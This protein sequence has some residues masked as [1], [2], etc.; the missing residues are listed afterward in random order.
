[1]HYA[2]PLTDGQTANLKL[3]LDEQEFRCPAASQRSMRRWLATTLK[4][5]A[6]DED[7]LVE[8][9]LLAWRMAQPEPRRSGNKG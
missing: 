6:Q 2:T 3:S 4:L 9:M 7:E 8:V 5:S 1:M